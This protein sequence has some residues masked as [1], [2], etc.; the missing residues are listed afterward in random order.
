MQNLVAVVDCAFTGW[1]LVLLQ[2]KKTLLQAIDEFVRVRILLA[3]QAISDEVCC[4]VQTEDVILVYSWFV[5]LVSRCQTFSALFFA[6]MLSV[7]DV[8]CG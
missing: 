4:S 3:G 2:A 1:V 7:Y 6:T 5:F 8:Y